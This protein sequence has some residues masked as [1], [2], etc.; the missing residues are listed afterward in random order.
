[1][2]TGKEIGGRGNTNATMLCGVTKLDRIRNEIM[3]R[4]TKVGEMSKERPGK[5]VE[6]VWACD[7]KKGGRRWKLKY[8]GGG[9]V[10]G[11][12]LDRVKDDV[13]EKGLSM[14]EVYDSAT[15]RCISSNID[16]A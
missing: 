6:V 14:E 12:W 9:R 4:A 13:G 7:A 16:L 11:L 10:E 3:R 2:C 5:E 15:W 1:M 8:N